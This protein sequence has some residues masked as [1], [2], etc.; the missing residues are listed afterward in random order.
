MRTGFFG[1]RAKVG[2]VAAHPAKAK[3]REASMAQL[4]AKMW[5]VRNAGGLTSTPTC[6]TRAHGSRCV[7]VR[8]AGGKRESARTSSLDTSPGVDKSSSGSGND[9]FGSGGAEELFASSGT[10]CVHKGERK[11]RPRIKDALT[12]PIVQTSTYWFEDTEEL[13]EY[14]EGRYQ[15]YEYGRY[16]NP[17]VRVCEEKIAELEKAEE[18]LVSS[19]GMNTATTMLLALVPQHGHIIT[20][21]DCYRRT[22][23]FI[24]TFLADKMNVTATVLD[25]SD[26]EGLERALKENDVTL[27][28]SES[29]T[30]PYL[31]CIDV[32]TVSRL[33]REN[34]AI[35]VVDGTFATPVNQ[36][37]LELGAD[38][39]I[40]SGTKYMAGHNDVLCGY[41]AGSKELVGQVKHMQNILGG[42]MDPHAGYLLLRGMKTLELRIARQNETAMRM[43]LALQDH[44]RVK[45]VHYPGLP[46]HPDHENAKNQMRGY[47]GVVS[48]EVDGDLWQTAKVI[49]SVRL[50]YI[51]PSLGGVESLI[52]QPTVVSYWDQPAETRAEIGIKDSLIRYACGIENF[53]DLWA[54]LKQALDGF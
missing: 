30:N 36:K 6:S 23:Q 37:P 49:D 22:R 53:E 24:Q 34:G 20:T 10:D 13:I 28:F 38:L 46:S 50:P 29:P 51:A 14:Q 44:P 12:T 32:P 17:T 11:G 35:S 33:C 5:R 8:A 15:S 26:L 41:I 3:P 31:R 27:Y 43:A 1:S 19:S 9:A 48:F 4:G 25:P 2:G 16:G 39:V 18:C 52:E 40:S 7:L 54:D 21:T 42:V 45:V 47:G